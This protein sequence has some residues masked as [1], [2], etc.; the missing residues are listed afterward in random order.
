MWMEMIMW[1]EVRHRQISPILSYVYL[2]Y[3]SNKGQIG[4]MTM[5]REKGLSERRQDGR[6]KWSW[7]ELSV[8]DTCK[9]SSW[10]SPYQQSVRWETC[11]QAVLLHHHPLDSG[12]PRPTLLPNPCTWTS[13]PQPQQ[14]TYA[15]VQSTPVGKAEDYIG[16]G[17]AIQWEEQEQAKATLVGRKEE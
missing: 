5:W 12:S 11:L 3:S 10:G 16:T 7:I 17:V 6:M 2:D 1:S 9:I 15:Q 13:S 4:E 14:T 8:L